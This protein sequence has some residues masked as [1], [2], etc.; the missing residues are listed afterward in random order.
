[1]RFIYKKQED[2]KACPKVFF[3]IG[4]LCAYALA[5]VTMR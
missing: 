5:P 4:M 1:M 3:V 2:L